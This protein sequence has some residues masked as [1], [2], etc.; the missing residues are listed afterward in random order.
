MIF[1]EVFQGHKQWL[2]EVRFLAVVDHPNLVKLIG[3]C[4]TDNER[5]TQRLLVYEFM[6]NKSLEHHL[7][8]KN[9]PALDWDT[10]LRI[11]VEIAEGLSY[12]HEGLHVP[13]SFINPNFKS[14]IFVFL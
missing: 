9:L 2:A 6:P 4:A 7:F 8:R 10:R 3:Y 11:A 14:P 5:G 13:V 12:L 1:A